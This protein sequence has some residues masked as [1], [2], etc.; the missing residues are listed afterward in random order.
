[1][2]WNNL[3]LPTA[4]ALG[5][6]LLH[7]IWIGALIYALVRTMLP[8]LRSAGQRHNLA[9]L[10]LVALAGG[11]IAAFYQNSEYS[12]V[13]E[14]LGAT[15]ISLNDFGLSLSAAAPEKTGFELL[16]EILPSLAPWVSMI[17]LFGLLPAAAYL[18]RD[19]RRV[20]FLRSNGL[21][22]LP[23]SWSATITDEL[24]RHPATRRVKTYLSNHAGEVMTL[25][26][27][28]QVIVFPVALVNALSPEMAR[29]ILLHEIA[30]LRHYDHWLNYPQQFLRTLFFYH[31]VAHALCSIIDREREH[32]CDDWV[33][34]RCNDRRTYA[35]ALVT[36]ARTSITPSNTLVMSATKTPFSNRIQRLFQ[37]EEQRS[38]HAVFSLL[39]VSLLAVGHLSFTSLGADAGA[40]DCLEEQGKATLNA[41]TFNPVII[42][43]DGEEINIPLPEELPTPTASNKVVAISPLPAPKVDALSVMDT[44]P[45]APVGVPAK[46]K[47]ALRNPATE[48]PLFILDGK[49][50]EGTLDDYELDPSDIKSVSV[51]KGESAISRFGPEGANGVVD[52]VTKNG[53]QAIPKARAKDEKATD[54]DGEKIVIGV[55]N[56]ETEET[57]PAVIIEDKKVAKGDSDLKPIYILDGKRLEGELDG[58]ISPEEIESIDVL[59]GKSAVEA[60]GPEAKNGVVIITTKK[61]PKQ[62]TRIKIRSVEGEEQGRVHIGTLDQE[63]GDDTP[64][65]VI[66]VRTVERATTVGEGAPSVVIKGHAATIETEK[67]TIATGFKAQ[68]T[69]Q[70]EAVIITGHVNETPETEAPAQAQALPKFDGPQQTVFTGESNP[71]TVFPNPSTGIINFRNV[72]TQEPLNVAVYTKFGEIVRQEEFNGSNLNIQGLPAGNYLVV[73][74]DGTQRWVNHVTVTK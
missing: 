40:V 46:Q 2:D 70:E 47:I 37:G 60:Y 49:V 67:V 61:G 57:M 14:N 41:P 45:P 3:W 33:A 5:L 59:K 22:S 39:F 23:T 25:G 10:G 44:L 38:G 68:E 13:C 20:Q 11:F 21:S 34:A 30:H 1:M 7:S 27:W 50:L 4:T 24:E 74:T 9:Y 35:T 72:P 28:S 71:V 73:L 58:Q 19:Q 66:G 16:S 31:P 32:R 56:Q 62:K 53:T 51:F 55:F 69:P 36:V 26:F 15:S 29:T 48:Q 17:Y 52:I 54:G 18:F 42:D 12:T 65:V 6:G 64:P 8:F 43:T 63:E